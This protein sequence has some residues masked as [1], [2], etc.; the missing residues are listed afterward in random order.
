MF[1]LFG[2]GGRNFWMLRLGILV[3]VLAAGAAFHYRG[4]GYLAVRGLYYVLIFGFIVSALWRNR[5][6]QRGIGNRGPGTFSGPAPYRGGGMPPSFGG[7]YPPS[8][9]QDAPVYPSSAE[10]PPSVPVALPQVATPPVNEPPVVGP[11]AAD[12]AKFGHTS[13]TGPGE[14]PGWYPDPL[15]PMARNYWDGATWSHRLKWDGTAWVPG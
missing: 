7:Q 10:N 9:S 3:L 13:L 12:V 11:S 15:D 4:A 5:A 14:A 1:M 6:R 8:S 2:R